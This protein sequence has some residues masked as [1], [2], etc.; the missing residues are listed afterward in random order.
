[1]K[2]E[3]RLGSF[4]AEEGQVERFCGHCNEP[5]GFNKTVGIS[6]LA[7]Q[8]SSPEILLRSTEVAS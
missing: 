5:L 3:W 7:E 6:S 4:G 1:M 8:L 2:G